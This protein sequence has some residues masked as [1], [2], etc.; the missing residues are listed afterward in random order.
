MV[1]MALM[2]LIMAILGEAFAQGLTVVRRAKGIGDLQDNL[3]TAAVLLRHDLTQRHFEGSEK[4]S[5]SF[6]SCK[7]PGAGFFRVQQARPVREGQDRNALPSNRASQDVL[8][9]SVV[10]AGTRRSDYLSALA[11]PVTGTV[12]SD[13]SHALWTEGPAA[14]QSKWT[15]GE[16]YMNSQRAELM[17]FLVPM[18]DSSGSQMRAGGGQTPLYTLHRRQR[19]IVTDNNQLLNTD[20][21]VLD[22]RDFRDPST[23]LAMSS[24]MLVAH[25]PP[26]SN[27][28][29]PSS[30]LGKFEEIACKFDPDRPK[31]LYFPSLKDLEK[32][33]RRSMMDASGTESVPTPM[34]GA[35]AGEDRVLSDVI[36]FE[37][38]VLLEGDYQFKTVEEVQAKYPSQAFANPS[39][40][41]AYDTATWPVNDSNQ[42]GSPNRDNLRVSVKAIEV[43]LRIWDHKTEQTRQITVIQDL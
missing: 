30:A 4:L 33:H 13:P 43:V 19:L 24:L 27:K 14:Y 34:G 8:H 36:S 37:V 20:D 16:F 29:I 39:G 28:R 42:P 12:A 6:K 7:R 10:K 35:Q 2:V 5:T 25:H 23:L 21:D 9:M 17:W 41:F 40:K 3:R 1:S 15:A 38:K 26:G 11:P 18:T 31:Y 22:L 32:P